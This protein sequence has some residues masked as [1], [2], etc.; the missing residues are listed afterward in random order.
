LAVK[1]AGGPVHVKS[2]K[3]RTKSGKVVDVEAYTYVRNLIG[4]RGT[5]S[6]GRKGTPAS[7]VARYVPPPKPVYQPLSREE[8][9]DPETPRTRAVS[10]AEFQELAAKGQ[11]RLASFH[12]HASPPKGLDKRWQAVKD[13]AWA[14][15]QD[16]WGGV[17]IDAHTGV[18]VT[19]EPNKYALTA[20]PNGVYSVTMPVG[21]DRDT[22]DAM[23]E[24]ARKRFDSVL[25]NEHYHLGV[26]RDD[27]IDRID[28][29]PVLV[30]DDH[31]DVESIGAYTR[32]EGGAY[33]FAD[34][35]GY[36]PPY[37]DKGLDNAGQQG[38]AVQGA[39]SVVRAGQ[40]GRGPP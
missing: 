36:W 7:A 35:L 23:M 9:S 20:R 17:T 21:S 2:Y 5:K 12:A 19:G 31:D 26:F 33:N 37:V 32:A 8:F 15:V 14:S 38:P 4:R 22:F 1:L 16:E 18:N 6:H 10:S 25:S 29:D 28:I 34:G 13:E 40:E 3:R 27:A 11:A 30:L 24:D 39:R